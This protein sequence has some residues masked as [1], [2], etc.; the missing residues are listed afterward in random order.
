[1]YLKILLNI[2]L[3]LAPFIIMPNQPDLAREPKMAFAVGLALV[4][5]LCT[6][7][8]GKFKPIRNKWILGL[9]GYTFGAFYLAP[10]PKLLFWGVECAKFWSWEPMFYL[11]VFALF[12]FA[13]ASMDFT[14]IEINNIITCMVWCGFIM[15]AFVLL[16]WAYLDQFFEHRFGTFARGS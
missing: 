9:I 5:V 3:C 6:L 7:Y 11:L 8:E 13:L 1:M 14:K 4:I 15:A 10:K 16:Q 12:F 2:G